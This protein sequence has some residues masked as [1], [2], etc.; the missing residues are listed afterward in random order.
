MYFWPPLPISGKDISLCCLLHTQVTALSL[1]GSVALLEVEASTAQRLSLA[2][3]YSISYSHHH[4]HYQH[5]TIKMQPKQNYQL[6]ASL[7]SNRNEQFGQKHWKWYYWTYRVTDRYQVV[8]SSCSWRMLCV[9]SRF[10]RILLSQKELP[11]RHN[12]RTL[13]VV[14]ISVLR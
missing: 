6:H 11:I 7:V 12:L 4:H 5:S 3:V 14:Q 10:L 13:K 8:Q 9:N 2:S 1:L